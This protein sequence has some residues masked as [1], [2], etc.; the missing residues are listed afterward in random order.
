MHQRLRT[1]TLGKEKAKH[2]D[3]PNAAPA[4]DGSANVVITQLKIKNVAFIA[5]W[6]VDFYP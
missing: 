4:T 6:T 1:S 2:D 3:A 5:E